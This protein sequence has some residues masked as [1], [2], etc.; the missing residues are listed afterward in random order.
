VQRIVGA[1]IRHHQRV[2]RHDEPTTARVA[3]VRQ[4]MTVHAADARRQVDADGDP[5]PAATEVHAIA[6][7]TVGLYGGDVR[8]QGIPPAEAWSRT[9]GGARRVGA[10]WA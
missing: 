4:A 1:A 5:K 8:E 2:V 6:D 10:S 7:A 9:V 3:A